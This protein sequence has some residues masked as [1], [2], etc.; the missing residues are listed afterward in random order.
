MN[1]LTVGFGSVSVIDGNGNVWVE[2]TNEC[3]QLGVGEQETYLRY[4]EV[5]SGLRS[6]SIVA[7][8]LGQFHALFLSNDGCVRSSG[9]GSSGQLGLGTNMNASTPQIISN[10]PTIVEIAAGFIHSLFLDETGAFWSCGGNYMGQ[11][12]VKNTELVNIPTKNSQLPAMSEIFAGPYASYLIEA[13]GCVWVT[14]RNEKYQLGLGHEGNISVP[15]KNAYLR[16]IVSICGQEKNTF[17]LDRDGV[18]WGCGDI[19][20][21][22]KHAPER[23]FTNSLPEISAICA[24]VL[25]LLFLDRTGVVRTSKSNSSTNMTKLNLPPI[26]QMA[27]NSNWAIFLDGDGKVW[28]LVAKDDHSTISQITGIPTISFNIPRIK[29][30]RSN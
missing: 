22:T 30:A 28:R 11:L 9:M 18:V 12:G 14:G 1:V 2:G 5:V 10:L 21:D 8:A 3:F 13:N 15:R 29:S 25:Q 27:A 26:M 4:P 24:T 20:N 19:G 17:F 16:N 7:V 6:V 23:L